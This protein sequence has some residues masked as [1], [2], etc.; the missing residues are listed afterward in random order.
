MHRLFLLRHAKA[1][2]ATPGIRDFDRP[3]T[4]SGEADARDLGARM[5]EDGHRPAVVLCSAARR[6]R[7]TWACVMQGFGDGVAA[8]EIAD[9]LYDADAAGYLAII[10]A[11]GPA[12]PVLVVGHNP[13][14]EDLA[15]ALSG[16]GDS[17]ALRAIGSGFPTCGLA[18]IDF[19]QPLA[20]IEPGTGD[21]RDFI[22]PRRH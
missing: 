2:W 15:T 14:M 22:V 20:G 9:R 1:A 4:A 13:I 6:A 16:V 3:L 19:A 10:T 12:T 5:R 11:A 17:T 21:L 8:A 18:V 7:E